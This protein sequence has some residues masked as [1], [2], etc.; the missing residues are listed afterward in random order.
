MLEKK[1][2]LFRV[3][4]WGWGEVG[5]GGRLFFFFSWHIFCSGPPS[6]LL[7]TPVHPLDYVFASSKVVCS[8]A[9]GS[10]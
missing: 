10:W 5:G 4:F 8:P 7:P 3:Y 6:C 1:V 9:N 2:V